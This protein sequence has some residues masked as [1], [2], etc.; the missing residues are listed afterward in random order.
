MS[1]LTRRVIT[2]LATA[3]VL[4]LALASTAAASTY[5]ISPY[6]TGNQ[7]NYTVSGCTMFTTGWGSGTE[8]GYEHTGDCTGEIGIRVVDVNG[9]SSS[10]RFLPG[11]TWADAP[12]GVV[13][14]YKLYHY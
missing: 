3:G 14:R 13:Y 9:E 5:Y 8:H 7:S 1:A 12:T 11:A 6:L 2:S 10:I 4:G